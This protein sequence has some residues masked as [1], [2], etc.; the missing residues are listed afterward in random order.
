LTN[1]TILRFNEINYLPLDFAENVTYPDVLAVLNQTIICLENDLN[2]YIP[3]KAVTVE[4]DTT[5]GKTVKCL[6]SYCYYVDEAF[7]FSD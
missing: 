7:V 2:C 6:W 3:I 1:Q 4:D 5:G